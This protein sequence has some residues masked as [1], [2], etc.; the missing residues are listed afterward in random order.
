MG[1]GAP[2]LGSMVRSRP[3]DEAAYRGFLFADLRDY[4]SFVERHGDAA[5][6]A[7]LDRY[8]ALVRSA[9]ARDGG[10]EVKTEGNRFVVVFLL[11]RS[12]L[13]CALETVQAAA[14][15]TRDDEAGPAHVSSRRR[16]SRDDDV[17]H[18]QRFDRC[19]VHPLSGCQGRSKASCG[20]SPPALKPLAVRSSRLGAPLAL[21]PDLRADLAVGTQCCHGPKRASADHQVRSAVMSR[22]SRVAVARTSVSS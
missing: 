19:R 9:V 3:A 21:G 8:R 7:L 5:A 18:G 17:A 10:A 16:A 20:P 12:A 15:P 6:S 4:T 13:R 1:E 14:A 11:A 22:S 2:L